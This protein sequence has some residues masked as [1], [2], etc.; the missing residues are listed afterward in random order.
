MYVHWAN[1]AH[2]IHFKCLIMLL[3]MLCVCI[4]ASDKINCRT[5]FCSQAKIRNPLKRNVNVKKIICFF[6]EL[7]QFFSV[8]VAICIV[9][10][11]WKPYSFQWSAMV[12]HV[13][14]IYTICMK[15]IITVVGIRSL[16]CIDA[17]R[18]KFF[19]LGDGAVLSTRR[20]YV[21][22]RYIWTIYS[23]LFIW[24]SGLPRWYECHLSSELRRKRTVILLLGI[25]FQMSP[26][27]KLHA[28]FKSFP[29]ET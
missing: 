8:E 3:F 16:V 17:L 26:Q 18:V 4:N 2:N 29:F 20:F 10:W 19:S 22:F 7:Y 1:F 9:L 6:V 5:L 13:S 27:E 12:D 24:S 14:F 25:S 15:T 11:E 23:R 21:Y 28:F